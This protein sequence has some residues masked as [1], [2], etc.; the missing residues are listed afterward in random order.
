MLNVMHTQADSHSS[1]GLNPILL[2]LRKAGILAAKGTMH[3]SCQVISLLSFEVLLF[4]CGE[5]KTIVRILLS[6]LCT[7][8]VKSII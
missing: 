5:K 8:A 7:S 4:S 2:I 1:G 3:Y 6:V